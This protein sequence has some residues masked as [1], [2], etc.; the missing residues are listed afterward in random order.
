M[1][2]NGSRVCV[3]IAE[4]L[5]SGEWIFCFSKHKTRRDLAM[6]ESASQRR[7][8]MRS[9]RRALIAHAKK[10]VQEGQ[11]TFFQR[12]IFRIKLRNSD[13]EA[14]LDYADECC[15]AAGN[16]DELIGAGWED[17][18]RWLWENRE[19]ILEFILSIIALF[20]VSNED[21]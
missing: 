14:C 3:T 11:L 9:L 4:L 16:P 13:V 10:E 18:L 15:A 17:F 5:H 21:D 19:A 8:R 1:P 2:Q 12:L 6:A 20:A 7:A